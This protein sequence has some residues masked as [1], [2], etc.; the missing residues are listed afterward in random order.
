[1]RTGSIFVLETRLLTRS[2]SPGFP[3]VFPSPTMDHCRGCVIVDVQEDFLDFIGGIAGLG[4]HIIGAL[5]SIR[6][7]RAVPLGEEE[8]SPGSKPKRSTR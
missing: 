1:M 2:V 6:N 7:A 4:T 5:T 8:K 3:L